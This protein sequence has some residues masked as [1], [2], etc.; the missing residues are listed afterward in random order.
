LL[1]RLC[2]IV[3]IHPLNTLV[4]HWWRSRIWAASEGSSWN[5]GP[6]LIILLAQRITTF[7]ILSF[8]SFLLSDSLGAIMMPPPMHQNREISCRVAFAAQLFIPLNSLDIPLYAFVSASRL[9]RAYLASVKITLS[10]QI[11]FSAP[12]NSRLFSGEDSS[13][14]DPSP[15]PAFLVC[16][17]RTGVK[18]APLSWS[19]V[20]TCLFN[21]PLRPHR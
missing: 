2:V 16:F 3:F 6:F 13:L 15:L 9:T 8:P 7:S 12:R 1:P 11:L 21:F 14:L 20:T 17:P 4:A 18:N 10:G 19:P 5:E